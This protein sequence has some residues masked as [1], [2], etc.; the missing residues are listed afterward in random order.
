MTVPQTDKNFAR[1]K[2]LINRTERYTNPWVNFEFLKPYE[3]DCL[4]V[5]TM[6]EY[7]NFCMGAD[8]N[9]RKLNVNNFL[10]YAQA[11]DQSDFYISNQSQGYQICQ[12]IFHP[13]ILEICTSAT[14]VTPVGKDMYDFVTQ[15]GLE[16]AFHRLNGTFKEY[17]GKKLEKLKAAQ[18]QPLKV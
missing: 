13:S 4:F 11:V 16:Y 5:G 2:I 15:D 18:E 14:N 1:E 12:G 3:D 8:L 6:R 10:E 7:N 9:I 17:I